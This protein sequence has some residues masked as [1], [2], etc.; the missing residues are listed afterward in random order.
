MSHLDSPLF[1]KQNTTIRLTVFAYFLCLILLKVSGH[2]AEDVA[3]ETSSASPISPIETIKPKRSYLLK[4]DC[5]SYP[6]LIRH[7]DR[8][9][10]EKDPRP[11]QLTLALY[12]D[13][14]YPRLFLQGE[15]LNPLRDDRRVPSFYSLPQPFEPDFTA[16]QIGVNQTLQQVEHNNG[17]GVP[18]R[19][20]ELAY[21]FDKVA[22]APKDRI[23]EWEA[24]IE[25]YIIGLRHEE[26]V[27]KDIPF[28][29]DKETEGAVP[30]VTSIVRLVVGYTEFQEMR[31]QALELMPKETIADVAGKEIEALRKVTDLQGEKSITTAN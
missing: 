31:I 8:N 28:L 4:L 19:Q 13:G 3:P 9:E 29:G 22:Y 11:N 15:S 10:W 23:P 6:I 21:E 16:N 5:I 7:S 2:P 20:F 12:V 1:V 14:P 30:G 24:L 25:F 17:Y 27:P 18:I 26:Y